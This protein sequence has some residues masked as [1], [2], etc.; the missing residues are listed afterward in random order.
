MQQTWTLNRCF[1]CMTRAKLLASS[2]YST[3][4]AKSF[5]RLSIRFRTIHKS[6]VCR[7][8]PL[9]CL[10]SLMR[11]IKI[12]ARFQHS[13]CCN[14]ISKFLWLTNINS[15]SL[16][17]Q[18]VPP[19]KAISTALSTTKTPS[20]QASQWL[21][22][23]NNSSNSS[24]IRKWLSLYQLDWVSWPISRQWISSH[25]VLDSTPPS[26]ITCDRTSPTT[27]T[28][29]SKLSQGNVKPVQHHK[30]V[31]LAVPI[32]WF[33]WKSAIISL[34]RRLST[35]KKKIKTMRLQRSKSLQ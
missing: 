29:N 35:R 17:T 7:I 11:N 15:S 4:W 28:I 24:S 34:R 27:L 26:K 10:K 25:L 12:K 21:P 20:T 32:A 8:L 18:C 13:K 33:R 30:E 9:R 22:I 23:S 5:N 16:R 3:C 19:A 14:R 6:T 2:S 31:D 1:R